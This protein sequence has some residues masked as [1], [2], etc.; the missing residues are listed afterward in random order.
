MYVPTLFFWR[1]CKVVRNLIIS[2]TPACLV[3]SWDTTLTRQ[4]VL[5]WELSTQKRSLQIGQSKCVLLG[6]WKI[7]WSGNV[8]AIIHHHLVLFN[9]TP[10]LL[11]E[12]YEWDNMYIRG[13]TIRDDNHSSVSEKYLEQD[14]YFNSRETFL[15]FAEV[16]PQ[17]N[18]RSDPIIGCWCSEVTPE[19]FS[20]RHRWPLIGTPGHCASRVTRQGGGGRD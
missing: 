9:K 7:S 19:E 20:V 2:N 15:A 16:T 17:S 5:I 12:E 10:F 1:L 14:P 8:K 4:Q 18:V 3:S 13:P 6:D 11:S